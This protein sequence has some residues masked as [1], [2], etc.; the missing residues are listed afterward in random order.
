MGAGS[1]VVTGGGRGIGRAIAERLAAGQDTVVVLDSDAEAVGWVAAHP[2]RERIIPVVGDATDQ[3]VA[4]LAAGTAA[5]AAPLRG[6]VNNAAVFPA[7]WLHETSA[8]EM[9]ALIRHNLDLALTGC[10]VAL[11]WLLPAGGAIVN[12][13]SHQAQRAVRGALAYSTAK[14]AIEGLTRALAVDYGPR[15]VRA[16]ALALGSVATERSAAYLRGLPEADRLAFDREIRLLQPLGRMGSPAEVAE[17]VAF[18]L[19]DAAGFLNGAVI[20][21]DGGRSAVGRDPEEA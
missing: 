10:A 12:M 18:L 6:W 4:E 5:A 13:S 11:R 19:S 1:F 14:A 21:L 8:A 17:V 2:A 7:A 3:S 20:P 9:S 15:G 16:N